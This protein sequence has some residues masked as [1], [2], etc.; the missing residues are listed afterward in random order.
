MPTSV[1]VLL[2]EKLT[3]KLSMRKTQMNLPKGGCASETKWTNWNS[4]NWN[5]VGRAVKS[6]QARIVKAVKAKPLKRKS[7][8]KKDGKL[9]HLGIP[10]MHDRAMQ[11]LYK[12]A[13]EPMAETM[14]DGYLRLISKGVS[15]TSDTSG[16][17]K[18]F[19]LIKPSLKNG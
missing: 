10:V 7:I 5:K 19:L 16:Y 11:T 12:M 15:I 3:V 4:I 6:L 8:L 18:I 1:M 13:P 9:R 14:A 17:W 2:Y